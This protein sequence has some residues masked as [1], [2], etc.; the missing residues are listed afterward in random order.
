MI[1]L[2]VSE[3]MERGPGVF[4]YCSFLH[5]EGNQEG[6][7]AFLSLPLQV[8]VQYCETLP[9]IA[10]LVYVLLKPGTCFF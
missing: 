3:G 8:S 6:K 10:C 7:E 9:S 4:Q 2:E 1:C 5:V